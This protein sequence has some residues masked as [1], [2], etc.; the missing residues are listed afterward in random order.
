MVAQR[1]Q[2]F[3]KSRQT[4]FLMILSYSIKVLS[5]ILLIFVAETGKK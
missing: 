2:L 1:I 5:K 3:K 4:N